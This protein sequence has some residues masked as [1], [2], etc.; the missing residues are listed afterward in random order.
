MTTELQQIFTDNPH[1][2]AAYDEFLELHKNGYGKNSTPEELATF[3]GYYARDFLNGLKAPEDTSVLI[4][5]ERL[6]IRRASLSDA[7]FM[8][9][10]ELDEDNS[11]WVGHWPLGWRIAKFGDGHMLQTI[12]EKADGT[13][14]GIM[15]FCDMKSFEAEL[16]LKRI[17]ILEKGRG[18]GK[19]ALYLAQKYAFE[20]LGTKCL[21][22]GTKEHNTRAQSIYKATGFTPDMPDPC[23]HFHV[24]AEDYFNRTGGQL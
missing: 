11:P 9:K 24:A 23:T 5:G 4:K 8:E 16:Q 19:E 14:I 3:E 15:I 21:S 6:T 17:A 2:K 13:P 1:Y 10:V 12:I 20:V 18:Y 7:D 22:L